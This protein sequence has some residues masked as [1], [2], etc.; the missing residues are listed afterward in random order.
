[1]ISLRQFLL[2]LFGNLDFSRAH[3]FDLD[4]CGAINVPLIAAGT[5]GALLLKLIFGKLAVLDPEFDRSFGTFDFGL[6]L[7]FTA[8]P[9]DVKA[10][11]EYGHLQRDTNFTLNASSGLYS[12][13]QYVSNKVVWAW[14]ALPYQPL[15]LPVIY[16]GTGIQLITDGA[17]RRV[18]IFL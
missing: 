1:M 17:H 6:I 16:N 12:P 3:V 5:D 9:A 13:D 8:A 4:R 11:I 10:M 7:T 18:Y 2:R 15:E 14:P